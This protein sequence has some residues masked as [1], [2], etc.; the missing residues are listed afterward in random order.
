MTQTTKSSLSH[1]KRVKTHES[2]M[3]ISKTC[4]FKHS[5]GIP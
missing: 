1:F 2:I 3:P 4:G 5:K